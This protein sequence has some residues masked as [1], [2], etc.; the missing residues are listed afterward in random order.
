MA[1]RESRTWRLDEELMTSIRGQFDAGRRRRFL[2]NEAVYEQ[3]I[4]SS[5][6]F[7]IEK[8]LVQVS[9][10]RSDGTEMLLEFMGPHT[11]IGEGA[12]FDGLPRFSSA[13]AVEDTE[14]IEFDADRLG[15][16]FRANPQFAS[17]LLRVTSLKQRI[18]AIR[19][20]HLVSREPDERI[21]ELFRRLASMFGTEHEDGRVLVTKLT[22]EEIAAMTGTSRVTVT[23][24]IQR[25]K[26]QRI[27]DTVD[28]HFIVKP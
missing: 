10:I 23:R 27:I 16:V 15:E 20:E 25:L 6:F 3:G 4:V 28:G 2:K 22:H 21:M 5:K 19:L 24:T 12:A 1:K 11:I 7:Y 18:L 14:V 17:A 9:I 13:F 26:D 8:G